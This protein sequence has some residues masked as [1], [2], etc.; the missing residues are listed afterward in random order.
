[1][2]PPIEHQIRAMI[3]ILKRYNWSNFGI[4][5]SKMAGSVDFVQLVQQ[6]VDDTNEDR[7]FRYWNNS[8]PIF[9]RIQISVRGGV[10]FQSFEI[11]VA[12]IMTSGVL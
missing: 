4:V 3:A 5:R 6:E 7:S 8:S 10:G 9:H 12:S 2:A 11:S 1:M